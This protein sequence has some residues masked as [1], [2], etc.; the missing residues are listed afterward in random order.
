M[1][2]S[3]M[4]P[5]AHDLLA[6]ERFLAAEARLAAVFERIEEVIAPALRAMRATGRT[7]YLTDSTR[8]AIS[9]HAFLRPPYAPSAEAEWCLAWGIRFPDGGAGWSDAEPR[10][11]T[12]PHAIVAI[13]ASGLPATPP[14]IPSP[15]PGWSV[16][17]GEAAFLAAARPLHA[18]PAEPD[19]LASWTL[20]RIEEARAF[21]PALAG[22]T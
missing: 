21:L 2:R 11:P 20:A 4:M 8:G 19:A 13:G 22:G 16:L 12:V 1:G 18:F 5:D 17:A 10:L 7:T 14:R 3:R 6:A 15:P 9:G